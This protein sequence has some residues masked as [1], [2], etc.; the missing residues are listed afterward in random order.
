M[1]SNAE[2]AKSLQD[3]GADL[4]W[5]ARRAVRI[6]A[7]RGYVTAGLANGTSIVAGSHLGY[8]EKDGSHKGGARYLLTARG[9][10]VAKELTND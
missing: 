8:I 1:L 5:L 6:A 4:E 7:K 3:K 10:E 2:H 9:R